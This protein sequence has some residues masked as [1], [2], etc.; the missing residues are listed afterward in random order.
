MKEASELIKA[1]YLCRNMKILSKGIYDFITNVPSVQEES[2][3]EYLFWQWSILDK[4]VKFIKRKELHNKNKESKTGADFEI[5][6]WIIGSLIAVPFLIQSKKI[7]KHKNRYCKKTL[8]YNCEKPVKQ[9]QLL[10]DEAKRQEMIPLYMYYT[11]ISPNET[12]FLSDAYDVRDMAVKCLRKP[13]SLEI[14]IND[15]IDKSVNIEDLF[16]RYKKLGS[17]LFKEKLLNYAIEISE[18]PKYIKSYLNN[19]EI[20]YDNNM[21]IIDLRRDI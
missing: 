12:I 7:I 3:T 20:E 21:V 19:R 2:I 17:V 15:M 16:C 14:T 9:Y 18:V 8:N 1:L 10:I 4:K 13:K 6:L 11:S 5:E